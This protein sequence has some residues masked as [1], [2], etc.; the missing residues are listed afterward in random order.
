MSREVWVASI[1]QARLRAETYEGMIQKVLGRMAEV[2]P[3][4][5]DI[6][7]LPEAFP[8]V[9]I[10][11]G[12]PPLSE[13]AEEPIG[14]ISGPFAE[15]ARKHRCYVICP[16]YTVEAGRYYNAA[17]VIDREGQYV[18]EYRKINPTEG[19]LKRGITP[20]PLQPPV[21]ETDFGTIGIQICYDANWHEN[22]RL[23]REAGAEIVFWPSAFAGGEMLNGLAWINKYFV[24]SSTRFEHP[25]KIVDVLG[26]DVVATGRAS[27]W[28][29]APM[30]LDTAVIQS[31]VEIR[32]LEPVRAKYGRKV[33]VKIK[34][35]EAWASIESLSPEVSIP[36]VLA[37]FGIETSND[38]LARNTG[39]QD[40]RRPS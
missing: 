31:V 21:F 39:L 25:T 23:L 38:M 36:E 10:P 9:G 19:E 26:D 28:V 35:V 15:F 13:T 17:G 7:C 8:F 20:G 27:E 33:L 14:P 34:H 29:C 1:C 11:G 2:A 3:M 16:I 37:E 30:N 32:K 22:W 12:R 40:A 18:G 5:P 24:V 6:V 4:Q